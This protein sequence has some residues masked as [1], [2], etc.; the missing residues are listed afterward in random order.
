MILEFCDSGDF[1]N[2]IRKRRAL[3]EPEALAF[4]QQLGIPK[5]LFCNFNLC[6]LAVGLGV[7]HE[8]NIIHRDLKVCILRSGSK[9]SSLRI[10]CCTKTLRQEI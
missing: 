8:R 1:Q 4:M 7:L 9:I 6:F 10:C 5:T 2:Y 3:P